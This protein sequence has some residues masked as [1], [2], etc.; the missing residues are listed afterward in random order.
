MSDDPV[1]VCVHDLPAD[2]SDPDGPTIRE[3]NL[4]LEH[5]YPIGTLVDIKYDRWFGDGA[6]IKAEARLWVIG[7]HRDCD[8]SPLYI[9]AD[10]RKEMYDAL[11]EGLGIEDT[12]YNKNLTCN[13]YE[14]S[15]GE[16][17]LTPVEVTEEVKRGVGALDWE[18]D[19]CTCDGSGQHC[20][21]CM[22]L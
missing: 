3:L 15:V 19:Q 1:I 7:H 20:D 2:P 14:H 22:S 17:S 4:S 13:V 16:E 12:W 11:R 5:L 21:Y 9:L 18:E 10:K 6:C 8:G